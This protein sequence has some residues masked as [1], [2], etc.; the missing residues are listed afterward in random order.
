MDHFS[1]FGL[2]SEDMAGEWENA[3]SVN[4]RLRVGSVSG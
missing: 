3:G 1:F 4:E 2:G